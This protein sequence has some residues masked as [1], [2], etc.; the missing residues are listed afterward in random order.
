MG[1]I[2]NL[3]HNHILG[4]AGG[5]AYTC[6]HGI[7][8]TVSVNKYMHHVMSLRSFEYDHTAASAETIGVYHQIV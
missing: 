3:A 8:N 2:F 4:H 1:G 5:S 7:Y 6:S